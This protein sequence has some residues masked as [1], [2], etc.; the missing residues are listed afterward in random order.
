M[1]NLLAVSDTTK[2]ICELERTLKYLES[3]LDAKMQS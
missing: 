1:Q 2:K 3:S